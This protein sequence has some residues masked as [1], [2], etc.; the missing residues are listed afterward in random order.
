MCEGVGGGSAGDF[1]RIICVLWWN[2]VHPCCGV[3]EVVKC[4]LRKLRR[5]DLVISCKSSLYYGFLFVFCFS[6]IRSDLVGAFNVR[7][8]FSIGIGCPL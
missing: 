7:R 4:S 5:R 6:W 8:C 1:R 2:L 3:K